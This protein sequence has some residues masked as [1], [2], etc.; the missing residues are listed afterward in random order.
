MYEHNIIIKKVIELIENKKWDKLT[1]ILNSIKENEIDLNILIGNIYCINIFINNLQYKLLDISLKKNFC[2]LYVFDAKSLLHH[3]I[4]LNDIKIIKMLLEY[5]SY[6]INIDLLTIKD[7]NNLSP[8][9]YALILNNS[10]TINFLFNY[11]ID[12]N[13]LT[14]NNNNGLQIA[15]QSNNDY[16]IIKK[17]LDKIKNINNQNIQKLTALHISVKN[18]NINIIKD[19]IKYNVDYN[20]LDIN[21]RT[22][23]YH[24]SNLDI[25]KILESKCNLN[26][27]D[28]KGQTIIH[29]WGKKN[30]K[31]LL[32][33]ILDN[34]IDKIKFNIWD[35]KLNLPIIY[36]LHTDIN[37]KYFKDIIAKTDINFKNIQNNNALHLMVKHKNWNEL[38]H[39]INNKTIDLYLNNS[40]NKAL[41][42]LL[43]SDDLILLSKHNNIIDKLNTEIIKNKYN[44]EVMITIGTKQDV[45]HNLL[46]L[47]NKFSNITI[48]LDNNNYGIT[49]ENNELV[50][51]FD[52]NKYMDINEYFI[53]PIFINLN[54]NT[55]NNIRHLNILIYDKKKQSIERYEPYGILLPDELEYNSEQLD[56][57]LTNIF[58]NI[59]YSVS[60]F[61]FQYYDS[62][63]SKTIYDAEG[64]CT[65][66]C[67]WYVDNR[68]QYNKLKGDE[69]ILNMINIIKKNNLTFKEIIRNYII[70]NLLI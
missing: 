31:L 68:L 50:Y 69:F 18:N 49:W 38:K 48:I 7:N 28:K 46:Y 30:N 59:K 34:N 26:L 27:Q 9:Y 44:S 12:V 14:N 53:I 5:N 55:N 47:K 45:Y 37:I 43:S 22:I 33:Y 17:I 41:N 8:F 40:E 23:L 51:D 15:L 65:A 60:S 62:L 2:S 21:N 4:Y 52:I 3:A 6:N 16:I 10:N 64:Y 13:T 36:L 39:F 24:I 67:I 54:N 1:T 29:Y 56:K 20:L 66:W 58:K 57:Q 42:S 11:D 63:E 25:L 19:I 70:E 32:D 35:N 61:G